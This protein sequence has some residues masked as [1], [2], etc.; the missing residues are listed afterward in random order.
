MSKKRTLP[1]FNHNHLVVGYYRH[2]S[3]SQ[4][5]ASI[6]HQRE[7]V[8]RWAAAEGLTIAQLHQDRH[9]HRSTGFP[10]DAA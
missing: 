1:D 10:A 5:E 2:W 4:N 8:K 3:S 6:E 7:L 9:Q